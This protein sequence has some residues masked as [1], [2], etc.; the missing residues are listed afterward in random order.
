MP[1]T[2]WLNL[3]SNGYIYNR[4]SALIAIDLGEFS[5]GEG[6]RAGAR[7]HGD[8]TQ[9][10]EEHRSFS[11]YSAKR[12]L[13]FFIDIRRAPSS[14]FFFFFDLTYPM[15]SS[16]RQ[17][18]VIDFYTPPPPHPLSY[19]FFFFFHRVRYICYWVLY[20]RDALPTLVFVIFSHIPF[21]NGFFFPL[22]THLS[23]YTT[24]RHVGK[25]SFIGLYKERKH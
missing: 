18:S 1:L 11:L 19:S 8:E 20:V 4:F 9:V 15:S 14:L 10:W 21:S 12:W 3:F 22:L 23:S 25:T 16:G 13:Y 2:E 17:R 6:W 7:G 24:H 5:S